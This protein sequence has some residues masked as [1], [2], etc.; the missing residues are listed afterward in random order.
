[1]NIWIEK[2]PFPNKLL[3]GDWFG[4]VYAITT[5]SDTQEKHDERVQEEIGNIISEY[6][7]HNHYTVSLRLV[8]QEVVVRHE[9]V[10]TYCSLVEFRV[11]DSY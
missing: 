11:R 10:N 3:K 9:A 5:I 8:K 7:N 2:I 1:M 4:I 6:D